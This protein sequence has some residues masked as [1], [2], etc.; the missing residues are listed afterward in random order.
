MNDSQ[1]RAVLKSAECGSFTKAAEDLFVSRQALKKQIDALEDELGFMIFIRT[2]QGVVKTPAGEEFCRR[3]DKICSDAEEAIRQCRELAFTQEGIRIALPHHP[4]FLLENVFSEFHSRYPD[5]KLQ[6][7]LVDF[8]SAIEKLQ[9]NEA[10]I[11]EYTYRPFLEETGLSHLK[12]FP[13]P[14]RCLMAASHPLAAR[15]SL[16]IEDLSGFRVCLHTGERHISEELEAGGIVFDTIGNEMEKIRNICY[17]GGVFISKAYYLDYLSP[18][19]TVKLKT[20]YVPVA[21]VLY[22]REHSGQVRK[23]LDLIREMYPEEEYFET[24]ENGK[25]SFR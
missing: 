25:R 5:I 14:Y 13:L 19:V 18:L 22:R 21:G 2:H 24:T 4:R 6:I 17:N 15:E 10:D 16:K 8:F 9:T 23:F 11:V 20:D 1:I 7:V 12:M 3:L